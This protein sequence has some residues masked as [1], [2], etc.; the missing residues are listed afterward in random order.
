MNDITK[1]KGT[2]MSTE[3]MDDIFE[4]AGEGASFDSSEMQIPFVRLI[5][6]L[7]PQISKKK[8]K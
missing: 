3:V 6:A 7:S 8:Q 1:T 2:A 5:Q 4:S